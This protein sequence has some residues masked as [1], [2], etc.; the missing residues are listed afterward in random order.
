M[1]L[2]PGYKQTEVGVI[3]EDW[4]V[5]PLSNISLKIMVGIASAATH[6]Y[7]L[8]GIP[9]IRNQNIK[10][11]HL[12]D[13]D[14]LF[15][16]Q[17]Y[18]K[19]YR[20]KRLLEGDL[21]TTRTGYPG[22]TCIVPAK[23]KAA[24]SFTTLIT[25]PDTAQITSKFLCLYIN[26]EHGQRFFESSQIGGAQ[27]NVNTGT[28]K[29]MPIPIPTVSE[30]TKVS[31]ILGAVE[32]LLASIENL[33]AKKRAIKQAAMQELLT[34]KRRLPG[35]EGEWE[36]KR[37]GEIG[38][39]HRG[40]SY[41]GDADLMPHDTA[42]TIRLLRS[43]NVQDS[44]VKTAELKHVNSKR[45]ATHQILTRDDIVICMANGSK[46][47]VGKAGRFQVS[48]GYEYTFGAFMGCFRIIP[49]KADP[50][51]AF[52]LLQTD[53]YQRLIGDLLAGSSINNLKPSS[54]ESLEFLFPARSEQQAIAAVLSDIDAEL[55][56]LTHRRDSF[57]EIK[58][59][60]MQQLLTGKIRLT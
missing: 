23:Y 26:S 11:G 4:D 27:K 53:R 17:E 54:L 6:A 40:V 8:N 35:F 36:V 44:F 33:I 41:K 7:R 42:N 31:N 47:L 14:L 13:S 37:L 57:Q 59:G 12:F 60:M 25:R 21:L 20:S 2:K 55:T 5:R 39:C 24:Q 1:E 28:L 49:A 18:E 58:Q 56:F 51:F 50:G 29:K 32:E 30:Q 43:N 16:D 48:D 10:P 46:A 34:G 19:T 3:P 52:Y 9:M 38:K 22:T 45:V 15:I